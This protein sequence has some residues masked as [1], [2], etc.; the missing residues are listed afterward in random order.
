MQPRCVLRGAVNGYTSYSLHLFNIAQ[1]FVDRGKD[2]AI[3]PVSMEMGKAPIPKLIQ[4]SL[5]RKHQPEDWEMVVHCPTHS[6]AGSKRIVY[7]TMW[8]STKLHKE[9]VLILNTAELVIVPS[10]FNQTLFNA[11]GVK[12]PMAKV[13]LGIDTS[14]YHYRPVERKDEFVFSAAG[15]TFA[16]GCRKR[17]PMVVDA[18]IKAFPSDVKDVR[19]EIKCFPDDPDLEIGDDRITLIREFWS[20]QQL[21]DWYAHTD[22]YVSASAGEGWGLHQHE[23]M[24]TGRAVI[25]V[26]FGGITEF[27]DESVG[28]PLDYYLEPAGEVYENGG[29]WAVPTMDSLVDRMREVFNNRKSERVLKA[30]ERAMS[31]DLAHSAKVLDETLTQAGVFG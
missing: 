19:L 24:A 28:Y 15:R 23:M 1:G 5:V 29:L 7:N 26:P 3:Y 14:I 13:P 22:A 8:E 18:F 30:S 16:G 4:E 21:A 2:V 25:S 17:I 10:T 31:L 6:P 27:Y 9:G 12:R 20:K 11:Q